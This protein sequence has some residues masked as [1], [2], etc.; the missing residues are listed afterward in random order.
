MTAVG[1]GER[2][3]FLAVTVGGVP[4]V[5]G[6]AAI[7]TARCDALTHL[8]GQVDEHLR[9]T[10]GSRTQPDN[11]TAALLEGGCPL[12]CA[13][14]NTWRLIQY[15]SWDFQRCDA[16]QAISRH[17]LDMPTALLLRFL[18]W[19]AVLQACL[20]RNKYWPAYMPM[21]SFSGPACSLSRVC[22]RQQPRQH[23]GS[24]ACRQ[25]C[26]SATSK[27]TSLA[28][29]HRRSGGWMRPQCKW[30]DLSRKQLWWVLPLLR[31]QPPAADSPMSLSVKL[32]N[33]VLT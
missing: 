28:R 29:A 10:S 22:M 9:W 14:S 19:V 6:L 25:L 16:P 15:C 7:V 20:T 8:Q 17:A 3:C 30:L 12:I 33:W 24:S 31:V 26:K 4:V 18:H 5:Q 32:A 11:A 1:C 13:R 2:V 27:R 21:L 23:H